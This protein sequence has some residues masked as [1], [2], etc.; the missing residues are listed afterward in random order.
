MIIKTI[1]DFDNYCVDNEGNVYSK[2]YKHKKI[3]SK[4]QLSTTKHGYLQVGIWSNG[5]KK[6]K[7]VHR[8]VAEAFIPNPENK[9][10]VNHKNGIKT[11]NRVENLEWTTSSE[12]E[13]HKFRVLKKGHYFGKENKKS[14]IVLQIKGKKVV[15]K[16]FGVSEAQRKTGFDGSY[17]SKC[18]R[19]K[20]YKAYGFNWKYKQKD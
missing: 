12:N 9:S 5:I 2:N 8:L 10:E 3:M 19:G 16:F 7:L 1:K 4:I 17:I 6:I 20:K 14:K 13:Y 18:C 11:D 15:G